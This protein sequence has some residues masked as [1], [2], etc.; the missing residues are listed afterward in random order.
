MNKGRRI[1]DSKTLDVITAIYGGLINKAIT[2]KFQKIKDNY[3]GLSGI[4]GN[5]IYSK[6]F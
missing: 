3:I 4:N 5:L 2:S 1:T 6:K